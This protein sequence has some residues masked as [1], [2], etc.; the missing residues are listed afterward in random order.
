MA[1]EAVKRYIEAV[2]R[3]K[4]AIARVRATES[5]RNSLSVNE[6]DIQAYFP[7]EA[8][9][10]TASDAITKAKTAAKF[11][12]TAKVVGGGV[13]AQAEAL[14]HGIARILI[15]YDSELRKKLK[16]AGFLKRDPRAKERRKFGLKKARKAPQWSKR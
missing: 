7:T 10:L 2:G 5:T 3:R 13:S 1:T 4:T 14:R 9:R 8:L 16:K 12:I 6:K 15:I 11:K